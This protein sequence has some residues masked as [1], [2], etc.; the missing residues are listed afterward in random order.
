MHYKLFIKRK[1]AKMKQTEVAKALNV[2]NATYSLKE[3][4]KYDFT[5]AEA[6]KLTKIFECTLND[7]FQEDMDTVQQRL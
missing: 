6:I 4:G 1:E 7:L 5:L 3:N 2:T